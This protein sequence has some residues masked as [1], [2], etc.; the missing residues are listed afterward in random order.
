MLQNSSSAGKSRILD[1]GCHAHWLPFFTVEGC[2]G[3]RKQDIIFFL[4]FDEAKASQ[5]DNQ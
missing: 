3:A 2:F 4:S 1:S 5:L